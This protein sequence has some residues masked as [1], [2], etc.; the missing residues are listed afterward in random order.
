V[1][2]YSPERGRPKSAL[3]PDLF[4]LSRLQGSRSRPTRGA[5]TGF[6]GE[7]QSEVDHL[8]AGA[9]SQRRSRLSIGRVRELGARV[10]HDPQRFL[11]ELRQAQIGQLRTG[12]VKAHELSPPL[13]PTAVLPTARAGT[14]LIVQA[15]TP[16]CYCLVRLYSAP[17]GDLLAQPRHASAA[18]VRVTKDHCGHAGPVIA[19]EPAE[20]FA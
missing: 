1:R 8:P 5:T 9:R 18:T 3:P 14:P 20:P 6:A 19:P 11:T 2:A 4:E 15:A 13:P 10:L 12:I 7:P 16:E 17:P